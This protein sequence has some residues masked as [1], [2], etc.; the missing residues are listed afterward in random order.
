MTIFERLRPKSSVA[1]AEIN[2]RLRAIPRIA[3][4][5]PRTPAGSAIP[6]VI[7]KLSGLASAP[8]KSCEQDALG[9]V[10]CRSWPDLMPPGSKGTTIGIAPA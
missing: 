2:L 10:I 3:T 4:R 8:E 1:V 5:Y 9:D 6:K 7:G